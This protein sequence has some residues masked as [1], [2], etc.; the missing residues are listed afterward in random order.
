MMIL[1]LVKKEHLRHTKAKYDNEKKQ[2]LL[3]D[4]LT[5]FK[6]GGVLHKEYKTKHTEIIYDVTDFQGIYF[7]NDPVLQNQQSRSVRGAAGLELFHKNVALL[8]AIFLQNEYQAM[9]QKTLP[10]FYYSGID[11]Q[12]M[13]VERPS[14]QKII[15]LWLEMVNDYLEKIMLTDPHLLNLLSMDEIMTLSMYENFDKYPLCIRNAPANSNYSDELAFKLNSELDNLLSKF[16]II[17]N[18]ETLIKLKSNAPDDQI[19][20]SDEIFFNFINNPSIMQS[21]DE[22]IANCLS[23]IDTKSLFINLS[24]CGYYGWMDNTNQLFDYFQS[25]NNLDQS[26]LYQYMKDKT[27]LNNYFN[28]PATRVYWLAKQTNSIKMVTDIEEQAL[29]TIQNELYSMING[30]SANSYNPNLIKLV[31]FCKDFNIYDRAKTLIEEEFVSHLIR[32]Y[33]QPEKIGDLIELT[34]QLWSLNILDKYHD[35][36]KS[37]IVDNFNQLDLETMENGWLIMR[38]K[39]LFQFI[40]FDQYQQT[41]IMMSML[42]KM[43]FTGSWNDPVT[44]FLENLISSLQEES[45]NNPELYNK[46]LNKIVSRVQTHL[47]EQE[48]MNLEI[49]LKNLEEI[50]VRMPNSEF[51]ESQ[52]LIILDSLKSG[53]FLNESLAIITE[54]EKK[55]IFAANLIINLHGLLNRVPNNYGEEF[56]KLIKIADKTIVDA[57]KDIIK[58]VTVLCNPYAQVLSKNR[59]SLMHHDSSLSN[60]HPDESVQ[61]EKGPSSLKSGRS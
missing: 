4:I 39:Y 61:Q 43:T 57:D 9:T 30:D 8:Q 53:K 22:S 28:H 34:N 24:A 60:K 2:T 16:K 10:L 40:A 52:K 58:K 7:T 32:C 31:L 21:C 35:A 23:S 25:S 6:L 33:Q 38:M 1:E 59:N 26:T 37:V 13:P 29:L 27:F 14:D 45:S 19:T 3:N 44:S 48:N 36:I 12:I 15:E 42:D 56:N 11:N 5:Q 17:N 18:E 46:I 51:T 49:Y 54:P 55:L 20:K 47:P 41:E 50:K